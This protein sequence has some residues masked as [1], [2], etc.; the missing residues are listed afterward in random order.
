MIPTLGISVRYPEPVADLARILFLPLL[1]ICHENTLR[2]S[3][4]SLLHRKVMNCELDSIPKEDKNLTMEGSTHNN[5]HIS[6]DA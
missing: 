3:M 4:V 6:R 2:V 5:V 1:L